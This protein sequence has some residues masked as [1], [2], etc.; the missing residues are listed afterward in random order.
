MA[1]LSTSIGAGSAVG[2]VGDVAT[3]ELRVE[4]M[5][6]TK[7]PVDVETVV[8]DAGAAGCWAVVPGGYD[9]LAANPTAGVKEDAIG[10]PL[11]VGSRGHWHACS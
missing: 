6:M 5:P 2:C 11:V 8:L 7:G 10:I 3:L 1:V 4:Q 9:N